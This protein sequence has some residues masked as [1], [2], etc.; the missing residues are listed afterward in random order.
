MGGTPP[1]AAAPKAEAP[2]TLTDAEAAPLLE[3]LKKV[4]KAKAW[5]DA[6][7]AFESLAG[8]TH[9]DLEPALAKHLGHAVKEVA[10]RSA[11]EIG[12]RPGPKT[13]AALWKGWTLAVNDKRP[14]VRGAILAA[15]GAAKIPLDAKQYVDVEALWRKAP[16]AQTMVGIATYFLAIGT[17]KRPSR[18]LAEW[19]DE[20]RA[21]GNV[22]D[23]TNPPA[24]WW[25]ARWKTWNAVKGVVADALKAI[26]GQAFHSSDEAKEWFRKNPKFGFSW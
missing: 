1:P 7:P 22:E 5:A 14:E 15:M 9:P 2:R 20:P 12:K 16:D 21:G 24:E 17:D 23:G 8:V 19:L 13:G 18:L 26:T 4:G 3:G 11:T 25:E 6:S 10:I